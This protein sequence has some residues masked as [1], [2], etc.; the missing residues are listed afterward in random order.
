MRLLPE[1]P[2]PPY[3]YVPGKKPHP[4]TDP[5]GHSYGRPELAAE[6][7]AAEDWL[8]NTAYLRGI[9]LFDNGF[10]W[11]AHEAW[12]AVWR[13]TR[14]D[15]LQ[16]MFA[17]ALIQGAAALVKVAEGRP[18]GVRSLAS[19]ACEAL[20]EIALATGGARY[21]GVL[22][23]VIAGDL[24]AFVRSNPSSLAHAPRIATAVRSRDL[25]ATLSDFRVQSAATEIIERAD[26]VVV[27]TP[28]YPTY[29]WGN[30]LVLDSPPPPESL[31]DWFRCCARELADIETANL[32]IAWETGDV[33]TEVSEVEAQAAEL[34]TVMTLAGGPGPADLP[35]AI[36]ISKASDV[37][38]WQRLVAMLA[39]IGPPELGEAY[40]DF[41]RWRYEKYRESVE[42]GRGAMWIARDGDELVAN[43]G[44]LDAG[45]YCRFQ[46][47][48]TLASHRRRGICSALVRSSIA[49]SQARRASRLPVIVANRGE[50]AERLYAAIGFAAVGSQFTM[51]RPRPS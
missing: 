13:A 9:D 6:E 37:D 23:A 38:T 7:L 42:D 35:P 43:L 46:D 22:P 18:A 19:R 39:E 4:N 29:H 30:Y 20:D 32:L 40:G 8:A 24:A 31:D 16:Q 51:R 12:E 17:Q 1:Q 27:R 34:L 26:F 41:V 50:A 21:M 45:A 25:P 5:A 2:L 3:A 49:D 28:E 33:S 10:P 44:L 36:E 11:E 15:R 48:N 14:Q 47:V